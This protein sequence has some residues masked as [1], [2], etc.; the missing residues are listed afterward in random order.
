LA[1]LSL[2]GCEEEEK[3]AVTPAASP[4]ET[5]TPAAA[6]FALEPVKAGSRGGI[7]RFF[8]YDA[9]TLDTYDPHQTQFGPIF[10]MHGVV[11][12]KVLK[13]LEYDLGTMEVDLAETMPETPDELTY[14][15]KLR[16]NVRF[17]DT[18]Q[19]R[20]NY[21]QVAGRELTAEDVKYSIERQ[22]NKESPKSALYYRAYQWETVDK[23]E[24]VDTLTLKITTK[25]PTAPFIHYLGDINAFIIAK[26]LVDEAQ[27]DMNSPDKMIGTGPFLLDMFGALTV[28]RCVRN[29]D[30]F[31]KDD[32]ADQGLPDRPILDGYE[33]I[34]TPEDDTSIETAFKSKQIDWTGYVDRGNTERI[35]AEV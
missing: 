34:W 32:L 12:S 6:P 9:L 17:H 1:A 27:D 24:V 11:F 5:V 33:A 29:P 30:W 4:A 23:I 3:A 26:E 13:Y 22:L 20:K 28:V 10:S 18:E 21:P 16:P 14:I 25:S 7:M 19:I 35:A 15:I 31:A 8:G 2:V